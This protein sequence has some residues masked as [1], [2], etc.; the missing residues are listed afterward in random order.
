MF[1]P[2]LI[3]IGRLVQG[4]MSGE[5]LGGVSVYLAEMAAPGRRGFY[6]AWQSGSQQSR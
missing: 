4:F 5:E 6:P 2:L 3:R 1:A